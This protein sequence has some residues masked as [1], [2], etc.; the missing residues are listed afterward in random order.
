VTS[1]ADVIR[2]CRTLAECSREPGFT[3]RPF[4]SPPMRVVHEHLTA[5]MEQVGM[6][7]HVDNAGNIHGV[8]AGSSDRSSLFIGS[9]LDT[10]PR[11][12]AF[13]GVLGVVLGVALVDMLNGER[14]PFAIDVIGFSEEEGVRFG[15]PFIGSRAFAGAVDTTL[16]A[17]RDAAGLSIADA[18]RH[19][20]LDPEAIGGAAADANAIGYV[21]FHIEQGP[22]LDSLGVPLGIVDSIV[23]QTR[24]DVTFTGAAGHA[25]TTPMRARRDALAG[26]AEWIVA[27]EQEARSTPGLVATVG[28]IDATPG[29]SNVIAGVCATTLDVR[30][31]DDG[32]RAAAVA[33]LAGQAR[34]IAARRGLEVAWVPRFDQAAVS[35]DPSLVGALERAVRR[36]GVPAHHL[37]SGAG[38]DA[39]IVAA[40]M[41]AAMLFLRSPGGISH[42]PDELVLEADVD[43]ALEVGLQF[44]RSE[45]AGLSRPGNQP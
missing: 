42:H 22:I 18:I 28:R 32:V 27:A 11:A 8:Y 31:A 24:V 41:P 1:A 38:H 21:E 30:H 33:R 25:G 12:G 45:G 20:G 43:V 6:Q 37:S 17:T 19:Y 26:A 5:W 9:H 3:T 23:G 44:L 35:M 40:R 34:A 2:R 10:V 14:F 39:M 4:L 7:V 15:V 29:A 36:A 13:D 16:L